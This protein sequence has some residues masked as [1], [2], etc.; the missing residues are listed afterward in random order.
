MDTIE[1]TKYASMILVALLLIVGGRVLIEEVTRSKH[2]ET[3]G[4]KLDAADSNASPAASSG[5]TAPP[6]AFDASAVVATVDSADAEAGKKFMKK[7]SACHGWEPSSKNK[8]GPSLWGIVERP[9]ASV[10]GFKYSEAMKAKGGNWTLESLAGFLHKPKDYLSGTKMIYAGI[11][12]EKDLANV[13]S[14]L[15]S[16]K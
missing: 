4:Y 7:C 3:V 5:Q 8:V 11:K 9:I 15:N 6:A 1:L 14:Y 10:P 2:S 13:L 16:L 12:K